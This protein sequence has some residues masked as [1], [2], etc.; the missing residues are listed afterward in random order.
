[1][2]KEVSLAENCQKFNIP[3]VS[4]YIFFIGLEVLTMVVMKRVIFWDIM[5]CSPLKVN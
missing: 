4:E 5:A 3:L 1:V 2:L